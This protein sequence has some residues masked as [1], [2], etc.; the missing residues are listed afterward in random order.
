MGCATL[1]AGQCEDRGSD[2][3][4][5]ITR[6][7][8]LADPAT[9]LAGTPPS[10]GPGFFELY[11][12][13]IA[14]AAA[15]LHLNALRLSI[16]WSRVFPSSTIGVS[17]LRSVASPAALAYYHAVF[18]AMKAH[19]LRPLVTLNHYTLPSWLHDA[20][21]C[22]QDLATCAHRGWLDPSA[23]GEAARYARFVAGEFPEVDLWATL[24]EPFT[25]VVLA[26]Y[27]LPSDART[28]RLA[29]P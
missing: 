11:P 26:G 24:N 17:D 25:A 22:H 3:Y 20:A 18:A 15:E 4:Q 7:E 2:W 8:L 13:D 10:G 9:H 16:E 23:V 27:L 12:Q 14:R 1:A 21:A 28:N 19:G 29:C 5:W 6:P